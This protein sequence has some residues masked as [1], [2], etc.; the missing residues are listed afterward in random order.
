[1]LGSFFAIPWVVEQ[2]LI[3]IWQL[4]R[5]EISSLCQ[6]PQE[7]PSILE[8]IFTVALVWSL[9]LP[10]PVMLLMP[11]AGLHVAAFES[12]RAEDMTRLI[13]RHGGHSH[14]S[15][16][17]REVP[18]NENQQAVDFAHRLITANIDLVILLTGVGTKLLVE[19][20]E[21]H[22]DRK[23][24]LSALA[25]TT[26]IARGPK[27]SSVLR[28]LGIEPTFIPAAPHTW[29]EILHTIDQ[30]LLIAEQSVGLQEYGTTNPSLLAGLEARGA[31]VIPVKI[32]RWDLPE[33]TEN[34]EAN[35]RDIV[36]GNIDTVLFTAANQATNVLQIAEQIGMAKEL[37]KA[38]RQMVVAS[39]GPTTSEQL[40]KYDLP[41]DLEP[42][43]HKMGHLVSDAAEQ[44]LGL[45]E[46]KRKLAAVLK[47]RPTRDEA[48]DQ[49]APWYQSLLLKACRRE[50]VPRTPIW[51]MRQAGRYMKEYRA[52]REKTTFLDL[53]KD[54][55]LCA[56]V[57]IT[58]A[59]RLGVDAA[60]IFSDLLPILEP[61]GLDLE[62][63]Q[64]EGPVIHNPV[65]ESRDVD[66]VL[67]L[68]S[69]D[70]LHY[71]ME[72]VQITRAQMPADLPLIGF[73]GAPF[74]LASYTIE[75][76]GSKNYLHTKTL[77]YRDQG[78]WDALMTRLVGGITK[79]L[80]A[81]IAAGVQLVQIFD[82][83]AGCL[84]PDDYRRFVLPHSQQLIAS[85]TRG[86][87][88]IHFA[89]GNSALYPL[90]AEAGGDVIG[91]DWRARLDQTWE[92]IGHSHAIMGNLDPTLLI[93]PVD[94]IREGA[95]D[96]LDQ[97]AGR[98][99]HIFNLGHGI[100]PQTPV[101]NV[102]GLVDAVKELSAR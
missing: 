49:N 82:S 4:Q 5:V 27:P 61:M 29:R 23:R 46:R 60:I 93:A 63:A 78:A 39:I 87:P 62:Y 77:M 2:R 96:I 57:A 3:G 42:E 1:M 64:G 47:K 25:D 48:Q 13:E 76:G 59:S 51:L 43:H 85:I 18:I 69:V 33:N 8:L 50:P 74:T 100:L 97:A 28:D 71:V 12:R 72:T 75:G 95:G 20:V 30:Q 35:I 10:F 102:I 16:S 89:T 98:V 22:V 17:M 65:R 11:F 94:E 70:A 7:V 99:G 37:R 26:T 101:E 73:A 58:A 92:S 90:L 56:E 68:E 15:P 41:V 80:N 32:Y 34:L 40:R 44:A 14:V 88:V 54:P 52:V 53:C 84:S 19:A 66:R 79:Y 91:I 55:S 86:I 31:T 6:S 81:Q 38:L 24:F 45:L 21:R 83:W 67:E 9:L 36:A